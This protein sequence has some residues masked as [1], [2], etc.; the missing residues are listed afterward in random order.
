MI[1]LDA[2][3]SSWFEMVAERGWPGVVLVGMD[4]EEAA[5]ELA[6]HADTSQEARLGW[7]S[8]INVAVE[9]GDVP[10]EH[11][12]SLRLRLRLSPR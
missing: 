6:M 4:G 5:W 1:A 11:A 12:A 7:L 10:P 9:L 2:T 8:L 3:N